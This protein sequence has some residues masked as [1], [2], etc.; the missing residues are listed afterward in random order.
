MAFTIKSRSAQSPRTYRHHRP[1]AYFI[2]GLSDE[3][4]LRPA[5]PPRVRLHL[6]RP[7]HRHSP[8]CEGLVAALPIQ[9]T[10]LYR[11]Y[12]RHRPDAYFING[13]YD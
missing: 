4:Q 11:T 12:R 1:D 7:E 3:E 13:V 2:N 10:G 6:S 5:L 9:G 8:G